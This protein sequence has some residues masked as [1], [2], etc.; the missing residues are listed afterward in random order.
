[1]NPKRALTVVVLVIILSCVAAKL[2]AQEASPAN[3]GT[4]V[5]SALQLVPYPKEVKALDGSFNVTGATR[6]VINSSHAQEDRVAAETL[7]EEIKDAT[8]QKPRIVIGRG[9]ANGAIYLARLTD[10]RSLRSALAAKGLATEEKFNEEGYVLQVTRDRIIV[11]GQSGAGLFY[12]VQTLRQL[13]KPEKKAATVTAVAIKDWP[14]MRWRGVHD[15][16][17]RGPVP[18]LDY[19]KKQVRLLAEYKMNMFSLYI[20]HVFDYESEPLLAPKEGALNAKE[21]KE[22]VEYAKKYYV[23]IVPEQQAFGHLHHVLKTEKFSEMAETPHGHVLTPVNQKSYDFIN[24]MYTELVPLFPAPLFHIGA[25]ETFELG[26]GQTADR[27]K[28]VGLGRVYLEHL[29]RVTEIMKPYNK[30][31][32]FWGDIAM[33]YPELLNIL[34]KDVIAVPWNY[35]A[36]PNFDSMLKPYKDAGLDIMVAPG[37]NNW[38]MIYPNMTEAFGNIRN[39]VRDGQ[40]YGAMGMLNTTWDDDGEALFELTWPSL[41]FGAAASWQTGEA[42]IEQF[43]GNYDWAFYRNSDSTFIDAVKNLNRAHELLASVDAGRANNQA[44]WADSFNEFGAKATEKALPVAKE[45]RLSAEA[46]LESLYKY[47][48]KAKA[49]P[50]TVDTMIMAAHRLDLLGAKILFSAEISRAYWDAYLN[51]GD[52]ARVNRALREIDAVNARL[53]DLREA[54]Y[55]VRGM[56]DKAWRAENRP[57]WLENVLV[58]YDVLAQG[59]QQKINA[60]KAAQMQYQEKGALPSPESMGFYIRPEA[61]ARKVTAPATAVGH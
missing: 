8:G 33:H 1:M 40:K 47:R 3:Q 42:S 36:R 41:V 46:A 9:P 29:K 55:R 21:V 48:A 59:Y 32:M 45:L 54:T 50:E 35:H 15:D 37:A 13:V 53:Q 24:R 31:L 39:F 49:H 30:R 4:S 61:P 16:I 56:Y 25:D 57:Y 10:D 28:E 5:T 34:P 22:L 14:T 38:N 18:T 17:S 6:I 27:V 52:R 44:L 58:R 20:E 11:G 19:M 43:Q 7:A 2:R 23:E 60:M 51:M 26:R 12:G